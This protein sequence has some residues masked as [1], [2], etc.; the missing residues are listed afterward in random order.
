MFGPLQELVYSD[1]FFCHN[2]K[3]YENAVTSGLLNGRISRNS[4]CYQCTAQHSDFCFPTHR[5]AVQQ[6]VSNAHSFG[7]ICMVEGSVCS[8]ADG[9]DG[10]GISFQFRLRHSGVPVSPLDGGDEDCKTDLI[11][12]C[13]SCL[14]GMKLS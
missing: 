12:N 14:P 3:V 9:V 10:E 8:D 4:R 6:E 2:C 11:E 7:E 13:L 5:L 1:F